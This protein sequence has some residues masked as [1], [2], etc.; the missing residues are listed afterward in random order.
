MRVDTRCFRTLKT[1]PQQKRRRD[2]VDKYAAR[3]ISLLPYH[4][5]A[6]SAALLLLFVTV[7]SAALAA[8]PASHARKS[9]AVHPWAPIRKAFVMSVNAGE[10]AEYEKRH[11]HIWPELEAVLKQHGVVTYSIFLLPR[12]RQLFAYV[13]FR[14]QE[15]WNAV[16]Q[17][18]ACKKWWAYMK[19][20]MPANPDNS[21]V[22]TELK[23]VFHLEAPF[24]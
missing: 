13:E 19:D 4:R 17:T 21:P 6:C 12:T 16:A 20:I 2:I 5:T 18:A 22:S 3:T 1:E 8:P 9:A 23:E 24:R 10:E 14:D 11:R 7:N 15:Q